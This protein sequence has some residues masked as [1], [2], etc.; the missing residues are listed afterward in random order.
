MEFCQVT[1][2]SKIV[3]KTYLVLFCI[4]RDPAASQT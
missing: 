4:V 3:R 2:R 1:F